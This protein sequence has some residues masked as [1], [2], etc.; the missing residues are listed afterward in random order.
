MSYEVD[1]EVQLDESKFLSEQVNWD[2]EPTEE[3]IIEKADELGI[4]DYTMAKEALLK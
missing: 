3:E 4:D 2:E 1:E